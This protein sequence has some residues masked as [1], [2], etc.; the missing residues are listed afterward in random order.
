MAFF[1]GKLN[2][3]QKKFKSAVKFF[4]R[5]FFCAKLL[6]DHIG[7]ALAVNR[8]GVAYHKAKQYCNL[9]FFISP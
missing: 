8:I 6:E 4:K 9:L 1:M 7:A 3:E 5:L 2:E